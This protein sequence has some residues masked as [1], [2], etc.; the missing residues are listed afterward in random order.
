VH[1]T[2]L[3]KQTINA[4]VEEDDGRWIFDSQSRIQSR[5]C[6]V[7]PKLWRSE[8]SSWAIRIRIFSESDPLLLL[9][10]PDLMMWIPCIIL[11][12]ETLVFLVDHYY[13]QVDFL[14]S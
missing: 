6:I 9:L 11:I 2:A 14:L 7:F 3:K 1:C 8:R 12:M 5:A 13:G 10:I 4:S